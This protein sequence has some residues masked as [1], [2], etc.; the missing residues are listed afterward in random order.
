MG[1]KRQEAQFTGMVAAMAEEGPSPLKQL[2]SGCAAR[3]M[4]FPKSLPRFDG[5]M[6]GLLSYYLA[7]HRC[8]FGVEESSMGTDRQLTTA[9][10]PQS[11]GS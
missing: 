11:A 10:V 3:S 2:T 7:A 8:E 9:L 6:P 1:Q 5:M 4:L